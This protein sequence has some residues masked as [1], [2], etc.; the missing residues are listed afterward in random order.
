MTQGIIVVGLG[1][2]VIA[3]WFAVSSGGSKGGDEK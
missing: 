1:V 2:I 3:L